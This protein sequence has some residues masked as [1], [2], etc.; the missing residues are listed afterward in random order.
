MPAA[1]LPECLSSCH[2]RHVLGHL[3]P[4]YQVATKLMSAYDEAEVPRALMEHSMG[5]LLCSQWRPQETPSA[6]SISTKP[7]KNFSDQC[8]NLRHPQ[9]PTVEGSSPFPVW[10][11]VVTG[12]LLCN[13]QLTVTPAEGHACLLSLEV[14]LLFICMGFCLW[15]LSKSQSFWMCFP[16]S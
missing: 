14:T 7:L 10:C 8:V 5:L 15:L 6:S 13:S 3:S 12:C 11:C 16:P 2:H 1:S 4:Q 9:E